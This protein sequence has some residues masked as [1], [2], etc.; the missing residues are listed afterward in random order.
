MAWT[1]SG[2]PSSSDRDQVRF[3]IQDTDSDDQLLQDEELDYLLTEEGNVTSASIRAAEILMAKFSR[4]CDEKVGQVSVS[5]SQKAEQYKR[6]VDQLK[7]RAAIKNVT[8]FAGGISESQ[9]ETEE[10]DSDRVNPS[11]T[12]EMD[13]FTEVEH[14][15]YLEDPR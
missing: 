3:I 2:D 11:F 12:M 7:R 5:Y 1:Y 4:M 9:K 14:N 6:L 10:R 15:N 8:P 13:D